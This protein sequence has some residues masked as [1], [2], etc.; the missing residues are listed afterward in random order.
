MPQS[1]GVPAVVHRLARVE[2]ARK[3]SIESDLP[4]QTMEINGVA[5]RPFEQTCFEGGS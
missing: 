5:T 1:G 2:H 4:P 3:K